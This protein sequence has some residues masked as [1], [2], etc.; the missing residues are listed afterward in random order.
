LGVGIDRGVGND[1]I[2]PT[3]RASEARPSGGH[4][5][6]LPRP[7]NGQGHWGQITRAARGLASKNPR[8]ANHECQATNPIG[9]FYSPPSLLAPGEKGKGARRRRAA[10]GKEGAGNEEPGARSREQGPE[11]RKTTAGMDIYTAGNAY[12]ALNIFATPPTTP[13]RPRL[14]RR[15]TVSTA[16]PIYSLLPLGLFPVMD[17]RRRDA[18]PV[19]TCLVRAIEP[20]DCRTAT[21]GAPE[22]FVLFGTA[23]AVRGRCLGPADMPCFLVQGMLGAS[24]PRFELRLWL[25]DGCTERARRG[26]A[27]ASTAVATHHGTL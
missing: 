8:H 16:W 3:P 20:Q 9:V 26:R 6:H 18:S 2:T 5:H 25:P 13:S 21:E 12:I 23:V 14:H 17:R 22:P 7:A 10:P 27:C 11:L 15:P 4:R 24:P 1:P 19:C